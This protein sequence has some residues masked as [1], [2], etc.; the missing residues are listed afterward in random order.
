[1][2]PFKG[3]TEVTDLLTALLN[4]VLRWYCSTSD[5]IGLFNPVYLPRLFQVILPD[6]EHQAQPPAAPGR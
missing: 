5:Q 6:G 1:M 4:A 2:C 3:A